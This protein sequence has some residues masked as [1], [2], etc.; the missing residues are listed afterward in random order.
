[1]ETEADCGCSQSVTVQATSTS[2]RGRFLAR[3]GALA[4]GM[5]AVA[6]GIA[7]VPVAHASGSCVNTDKEIHWDCEPDCNCGE[8]YNG[9]MWMNEYWWDHDT[10]YLCA[11]QSTLVFACACAP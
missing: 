2:T 10:H 5:L 9:S 7:R 3:V 1:M 8:P 4:A 6:S 11:Y